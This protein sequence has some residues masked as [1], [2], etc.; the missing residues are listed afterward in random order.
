MKITLRYVR[1]S[2]LHEVIKQLELTCMVTEHLVNFLLYHIN[3]SLRANNP[4]PR[5][6]T[7]K[8]F[9]FIQSLKAAVIHVRVVVEYMSNVHHPVFSSSENRDGCE[10][11]ISL[12]SCGSHK[13]RGVHNE[14]CIC[15]QYAA[16]QIHPQL[17]WKPW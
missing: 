10:M 7:F 2:L 6:P 3:V 16:N 12:E 13:S 11:L 17:S 9:D 4:Y 5:V 8:M 1:L 15:C 14:H